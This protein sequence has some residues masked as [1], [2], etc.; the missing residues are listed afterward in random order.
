MCREKNLANLS[1]SNEVID[2]HLVAYFLL[3]LVRLEEEPRQAGVWLGGEI[4]E[5]RT[6]DQAFVGSTPGWVA[7]ECMD[8]ILRTD[9]NHLGI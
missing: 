9:L 6:Y 8:T 7:I 1:I 3:H 4:V 5:R 2:R